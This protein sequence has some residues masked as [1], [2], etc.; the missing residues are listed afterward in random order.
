MSFYNG[1]IT[2][3]NDVEYVSKIPMVKQ[4]LVGTDEGFLILYDKDL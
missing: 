2:A 3:M 1:M 4:F